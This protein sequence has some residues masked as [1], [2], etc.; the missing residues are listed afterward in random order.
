[1]LNF[2]LENPI[3][4]LIECVVINQKSEVLHLYFAIYLSELKMH[5]FFKRDAGEW[6][7]RNWLCKTEKL[8]EKSCGLITISC[9]YDGMIKLD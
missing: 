6:F 5:A 1:M 3:V 8:C 9:G 4:N 2:A 7:P